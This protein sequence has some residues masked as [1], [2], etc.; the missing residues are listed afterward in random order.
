MPNSSYPINHKGTLL[1]NGKPMPVI[2]VE[3]LIGCTGVPVHCTA[4][5]KDFTADL[6]GALWA[7]TDGARPGVTSEC[8]V[9]PDCKRLIG[10][11]EP[12]SPRTLLVD[13]ELEEDLK[14]AQK[15]GKELKLRR[16][17]S[18]NTVWFFPHFAEKVQRV[19]A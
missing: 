14:R 18:R 9:C 10:Y 16:V 7:L 17:T 13:R 2:V 15:K 1:S 12:V 8:P 5:E 3:R 19:P 11:K 6:D 4:C